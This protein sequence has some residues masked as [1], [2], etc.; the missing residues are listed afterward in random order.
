[1]ENLC[2]A[3]DP[4]HPATFI[5]RPDTHT[6]SFEMP[7]DEAL[8]L[9]TVDQVAEIFGRDRATIDRWCRERENFLQ[10]IQLR[11]VGSRF[12][13]AEIEDLYP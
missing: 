3:I 2:T 5:V 7:I 12:L 9:L 13:A 8:R 11:P 1:M 6:K 4:Q 10:K